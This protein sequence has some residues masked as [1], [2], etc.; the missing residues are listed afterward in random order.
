MLSN[1]LAGSGGPCQNWP[2]LPDERLPAL[3]RKSDSVDLM[4]DPE[5]LVSWCLRGLAGQE[6]E[7]CFSVPGGIGRGVAV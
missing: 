5:G 2:G 6:G 4:T 7:T 1:V 3:Y